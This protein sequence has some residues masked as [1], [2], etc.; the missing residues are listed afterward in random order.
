MTN[1]CNK[2][3]YDSFEKKVGIAR[4][5][6]T[7]LK[8]KIPEDFQEKKQLLDAINGAIEVFKDCTEEKLRQ[9]L[10]VATKT[11]AENLI[12]LYLDKT[13]DRWRDTLS[14]NKDLSYPSEIYKSQKNDK[15]AKV[16]GLVT[17]CKAL[18]YL[19]KKFKKYDD[20][21]IL[22]RL[23]LSIQKYYRGRA[24]DNNKI[25]L[26]K[27]KYKKSDIEKLD[28]QAF[29]YKTIKLQ[30]NDQLIGGLSAQQHL[31]KRFNNA[32]F[33]QIDHWMRYALTPLDSNEPYEYDLIKIKR[34]S[35]V[36]C[37][38]CFYLKN[39]VEEFQPKNFHIQLTFEEVMRRK[40]WEH[41]DEEVAVGLL[42][43]H[44]RKNRSFFMHPTEWSAAFTPELEES[45]RKKEAVFILPGIEAIESELASNYIESLPAKKYTV[46]DRSAWLND[47]AKQLI[48][49]LFDKKVARPTRKILARLVL[50]TGQ[51]LGYY[52]PNCKITTVEDDLSE[53]GFRNI[54]DLIYCCSK[55]PQ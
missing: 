39:E 53:I 28:H 49:E 1:Q 12:E 23:W 47:Y 45:I 22:W 3:K 10:E 4:V 50:P 34:D 6:I 5:I 8:D 33:A 24:T 29:C 54:V 7:T 21:K 30:K 15:S 19:K 48:K 31:K 40:S 25:E 51:D 43:H 38:D 42:L 16:T 32:T 11:P 46:K 9:H 26:S 17:H 52:K 13:F 44:S 2:K 36:A 14:A 20:G 55:E 41:L 27:I 37:S 35:D 18:A